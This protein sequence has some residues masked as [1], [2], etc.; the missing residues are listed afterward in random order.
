MTEDAVG[1][2]LVVV[3]S[4]GMDVVVTEAVT[5]VTET[6]MM[7]EETAVVEIDVVVV[8]NVV[9]VNATLIPIRVA[10]IARGRR[11]KTVVN[12]AKIAVVSRGATMTTAMWTAATA[13]IKTGV[14]YVMLYAPRTRRMRLGSWLK[15]GNA[16]K[17]D[18]STRCL[19]SWRRTNAG[20]TRTSSE[21]MM[22]L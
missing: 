9:M 13:V 7:K 2:N 20:R 15:N 18:V 21:W 19:N 14:K 6:M 16:K 12:A 1:R 8:M 10:R 3:R 22:T 11:R 5:V 17:K 4:R